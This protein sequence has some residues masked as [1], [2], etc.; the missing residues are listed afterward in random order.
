MAIK[1]MASGGATP[2]LQDDANAVVFLVTRPL[3]LSPL[4]TPQPCSSTPGSCCGVVDGTEGGGG[5]DM[6]EDLQVLRVLASADFGSSLSDL[7]A[8]C[9]A[10]MANS[11]LKQGV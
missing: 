1:V 4:V 11:A 6:S 7:G 5:V 3:I 8:V 10:D 9:P 2:P